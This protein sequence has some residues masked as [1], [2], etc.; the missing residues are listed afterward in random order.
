MQGSARGARP[1]EVSIVV[2]TFREAANIP[3]L[4]E[5]I[6]TALSGSGIEWE[7][8]LIDDDSGDG[9]EAVVAEL[10][11]RL[12]VRME[13]RRAVPR[14]LSLAVLQGLRLS[15]CERVV[16][17]DADLSHPPERIPDLLAA[18]DGDCDMAIGSRYVSG[19]SFGRAW[20]L[21][22]FLN[23]R[24]ATVLTLPLV[25]C[26]DPM[27]GFFAIRR[28]LLPG[29][30]PEP[31]TL[32]PVGYKIAL[33][34]MVRLQ[35]RLKE[36]P[37][38]FQ[39]RDRGASKMGWRQRFDY[40]RHL[41]RLYLHRFGDLLRM[42]Y[43]GFVGASGFIV[44]VVCYLCLQWLGLGHRLARFISF[45]PAVTWNW[46]LNRNLSFSGRSH[47]PCA[48][49]WAGFVASS[50]L[51]FGVSYGTYIVLTA[52]VPVFSDYRLLALVCGVVLGGVVNFLT[53]NLYVYR[54]HSD[55]KHAPAGSLENVAGASGSH[56]D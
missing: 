50:L 21:W 11:R 23:S 40:L 47:R 45:W 31:S 52:F 28:R 6:R 42:L 1:R 20:G 33:E 9:S 49:Q 7:L 24:L 16:V 5:R 2:P 8:L 35:P 10:A 56:E 19:G 38:E 53:A 34:L 4:A 27:S 13:V 12:P 43:F 22:R 17:M 3:T 18:L 44:D 48:R 15:R 55:D 32:R 41:H 14:D 30:G 46:W 36:V 25:N 37:Y 54:L 51:G 26:S 29:P 39:D